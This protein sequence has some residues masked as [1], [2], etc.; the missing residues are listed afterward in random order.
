MFLR[1]AATFAVTLTAGALL[2]AALA[3]RQNP[4]TKTEPSRQPLPYWA[5]TV[6]PPGDGN[7]A[8]PDHTKWIHV[9]GSAAAFTAAQT[10]DLFA[11]PDWHPDGHPSM[12]EIVAR[13]RKPD[14]Y[15]C[16]YCHLPN[17]QGRPENSSLAGLP[18]AYI[19]QQMADFKTGLRK[20]SE[21]K[22]L[23]V[24]NMISHETL[25]NE[26]EVRQAADYFSKL[27][28]RTW[29]RVV[30]TDNV[31]KTH[32]AGWLL[33]ASQP[34][35]TEP[36]GRRIIEMAENLQRTE[37]RDDDSGFVAYVPM[38]SL[39][40]GEALVIT[41]GAGKTLPCAACHGIDLRGLGNVPSIAGRSP[42]YIV[43]QLYD[44]QSGARS[45]AIATKQMGPV[46]AKL[47]V[48][49]MLDIAAYAASL[50]P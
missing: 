26:D 47:S 17:G 12:P 31:A 4:E 41:G 32:V 8:E 2:F 49:D 35:E 46:V 44:M 39:K 6:N 1:G 33:V 18:A 45:G 43:R 13:G 50:H 34:A 37:L 21:P 19:T 25:A 23:P 48:G 16:G 14:V 15:A 3:E 24:A 28:A 20:S 10:H 42:S 7:E 9:P 5:F 36:I 11:S 40:R 29:I 27:K 22:S 38:G 30:E